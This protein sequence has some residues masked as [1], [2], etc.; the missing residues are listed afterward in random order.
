MVIYLSE[1]QSTFRNGKQSPDTRVNAKAASRLDETSK[2]R[3]PNNTGSR[4]EDGP[5]R[6]SDNSQL[7][8]K[9]VQLSDLA[10]I[11]QQQTP[12]SQLIK[13]EEWINIP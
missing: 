4:M 13:P 3:K 11:S 8:T 7:S 6:N 1:M 9:T 10:I 2:D 12:L 5:S